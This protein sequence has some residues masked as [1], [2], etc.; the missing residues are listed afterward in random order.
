MWKQM[1]YDWV[2]LILLGIVVTTIAGI[3]YYSQYGTTMETSDHL[4]VI[5]GTFLLP[6][7]WIAILLCWHIRGCTKKSD[8]IIKE[9][10]EPILVRAY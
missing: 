5:L 6:I 9:R 2:L 3:V 1:I 10:M 7:L 8:A 4:F